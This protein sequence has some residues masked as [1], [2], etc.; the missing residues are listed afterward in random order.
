MVDI[1]KKHR[2]FCAVFLVVSLFRLRLI[3]SRPLGCAFDIIYKNL[4][5]IIYKEAVKT[6]IIDFICMRLLGRANGWR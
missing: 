5:N 6:G 4:A 2:T 3:L 1:C